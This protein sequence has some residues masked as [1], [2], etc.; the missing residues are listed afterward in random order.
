MAGSQDVIPEIDARFAAMGIDPSA[1]LA[2]GQ[3]AAQELDAETQRQQAEV[4][5][6]EDAVQS[7]HTDTATLRTRLEDSLRRSVESGVVK[8]R[9]DAKRQLADIDARVARGPARSWI[10][11]GFAGDKWCRKQTYYVTVDDDGNIWGEF[12]EA[13]Y[14]AAIT[15]QPLA[16]GKHIVHRKPTL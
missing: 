10:Y 9:E 14:D 15:G 8:T 4:Q 11:N 7:V 13:R 6:W 3:V 16:P 5:K 2:A 12:V 1:F